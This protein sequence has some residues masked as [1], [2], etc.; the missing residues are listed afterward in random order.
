[1]IARVLAGL[2]RV[3]G[4]RFRH[5]RSRKGH[6]FQATP[7]SSDA[8]DARIHPVKPADPSPPGGDTARD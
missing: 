2:G 4:V 6:A 3:F 5:R 8:H 1:M 7:R